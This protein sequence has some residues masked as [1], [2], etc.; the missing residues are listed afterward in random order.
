MYSASGPFALQTYRLYAFIQNFSSDY[1]FDM[2]D[3]GTWI[4]TEKPK[5]KNNNTLMMIHVSLWRVV[6]VIE[7]GQT[8]T[9]DMGST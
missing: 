1:Y 6:R 4:D 3:L 5:T 8:E 9:E 2:K 7:I